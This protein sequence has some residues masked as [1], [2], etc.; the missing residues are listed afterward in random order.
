MSHK[1]ARFGVQ[2]TSHFCSYEW[3]MSHIWVSHITHL[4]HM[5]ESCLH[6]SHIDMSCCVQWTSHVTHRNVS[7]LHRS[8]ELYESRTI[9]VT[10]HTQEY[11]GDI[12]LHMSHVHMSNVHMSHELY[13]SRMICTISIWVTNYIS[14][15][16]FWRVWWRCHVTHE[17]RT[18]ESRMICVIPIWDTNYMSHEPYTRVWWGHVTHEARTIWVTNNMR[19]IYMSQELYESRITWESMVEIGSCCKWVTNYMSHGWSALCFESWTIWNTSCM[20]EYGGDGVML[21]VG[22]GW[23]MSHIGIRDVTKRNV[24]C[25]VRGCT[26]MMIYRT[27]YWRWWSQYNICWRQ[28]PFKISTISWICIWVTWLIPM[29]DMTH[30]H[31]YTWFVPWVNRALFSAHYSLWGIQKRPIHTRRIRKSPIFRTT[32]SF[33]WVKRGIYCPSKTRRSHG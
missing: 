31:V 11:G 24:S 12:M 1:R 21:P 9:W 16:T 18:H 7:C 3:V 4:A 5:Y 33:P 28:R 10:I 25:L 32:H 17:S 15:E 14:H 22:D 19:D 8:H 26:A 2:W 29:C 30:S 23:V 13:E 20:G 27:R 6:M